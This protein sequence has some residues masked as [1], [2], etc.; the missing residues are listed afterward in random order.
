MK[1]PKIDH[2]VASFPVSI[3][4]MKWEI[5]LRNLLSAAVFELPLIDNL[6]DVNTVSQAIDWSFDHNC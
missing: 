5:N 2:I 1:K 4:Y 3:W 6:E